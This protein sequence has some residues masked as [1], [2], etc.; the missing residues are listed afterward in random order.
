MILSRGTHITPADLPEGI[1][2][3]VSKS[4]A[5]P[6]DIRVAVRAFERDFLQRVINECDGNKEE[7]ARRMNINSST[8]YRKL[9]DLDAREA[10]LSILQL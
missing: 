4:P 9:T 10:E 2:S 5:A 7:A 8:L 1:S 3:C 6:D